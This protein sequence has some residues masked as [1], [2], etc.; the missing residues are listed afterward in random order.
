MDASSLLAIIFFVIGI[1]ILIWIGILYKKEH[2]KLYYLK[3]GIGNYGS[4]SWP[5]PI[6][7][8]ICIYK[9]DAKVVPLVGDIFNKQRITKVN[10]FER[11]FSKS[12]E[13]FIGEKGVEN[14]DEYCK[15]LK[16]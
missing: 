11:K 12:A 13:I 4:P 10:I 9:R 8:W 5:Y 1:I 2:Y 3:W 16:K 14:Y 7:E 6:M 15:S